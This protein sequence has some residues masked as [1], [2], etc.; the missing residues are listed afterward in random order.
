MTSPLC[1]RSAT[2]LPSF[3]ALV[4]GV[5]LGAAACGQVDRDPPTIASFTA[6]A[7]VV[8]RGSAAMLVAEFEG[9]IATIDQGVGEIQSGVPVEVMPSETTLY[10]LTV[11]NGEDE[12]ATAD[13]S[14]QVFDGVINVTVPTGSGLG[15][16]P[17]AM[18]AAS[19]A[20]GRNAVT[21]SLPK[22]T[23][24]ELPATLISTGNITLLGPGAEELSIT[25]GDQ[26]RIF[27]VRSGE[28]AVHDL[29]LM[30]GRGAGGAGGKSPGASGGGGGAGMGGAL[31]INNATVTL[32]G[33]VISDSVAQG[34]GGGA[35]SGGGLANG[36]GGGGFGGNGADGG[37]TA[38]G[39][40]GQGGSGG[41]L[42]GVG[43]GGG[44]P[45]TGDGAGGGGAGAGVQQNGGPGTFGA[46]GGGSGGFPGA[47]AGGFGGGSGGGANPVPGMFGGAGQNF[48]GGGGGGGAGLGGAVF[49][50]A[51][52]LTIDKSSFRNNR[53]LAGA[54]AGSASAGKAK[55]GAIFSMVPTVTLGEVTYEGNAAADALGSGSDTADAY[56]TP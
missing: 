29:A 17:A 56:I 36:G 12:A 10:T 5:V 7:P 38:T 14:V 8:A 18:A 49:L 21:F 39:Q 20:S 45:G 4:L 31:F 1:S 11:R 24:I 19:A 9:G 16:L 46:G 23:V 32:T 15:S 42:N 13:A 47:G 41:E 34:G 50:R 25:G 6:S 33:V 35:S 52:K 54:G 2:S 3:S 28:L 43:G 53:A 51:G 30:H 48:T 55:G 27:F 26:R 37:T 44:A 40:G 22:Q